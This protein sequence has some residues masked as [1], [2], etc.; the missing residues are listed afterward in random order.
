MS[1]PDVAVGRARKRATPARARPWRDT[2]EHRKAQITAGQG[3]LFPPDLSLPSS[4]S[5]PSSD[6]EQAAQHIFPSP[7][8]VPRGPCMWVDPRL[9]RPRSSTTEKIADNTLVTL[10]HRI[11][12]YF[13][14]CIK[15][16]IFFIIV[17]K[18]T[19]IISSFFNNKIR[20]HVYCT[21]SKTLVYKEKKK[22]LEYWK[23]SIYN[24][25]LLLSVVAMHALCVIGL[26]DHAISST[27]DEES[28]NFACAN[29]KESLF[30]PIYAWSFY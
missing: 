1:V 22:Q 11:T 5:S 2:Q 7:C 14:F 27:R 24:V 6:W 17:A 13:L 12:C 10:L 18:N 30:V 20:R 4:L 25:D 23:P 19:W 15:H 8:R 9:V 29:G 26:Q 21:R 28:T 16:H 3:S